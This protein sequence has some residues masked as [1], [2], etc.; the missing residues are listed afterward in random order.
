MNDKTKRLSV[1]IS[2][3]LDRLIDELADDAKITRAD[4]VRR[5]L[6]IMKAYKQQ[7]A[8]GRTHIGFTADASKLDAELLNVL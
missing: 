3:D 4:V 7:K 8:H 1:N 6:A 2:D 5:A